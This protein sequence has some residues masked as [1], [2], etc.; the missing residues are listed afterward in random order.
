[1]ALGML[2]RWATELST[3]GSKPARQSGVARRASASSWRRTMTQM[4]NLLVMLNPRAPF[5]RQLGEPKALADWQLLVGRGL[6]AIGPLE[7]FG[8]VA[9]QLGTSLDSRISQWLYVYQ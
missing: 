9:P 5:T 3:L 8:R 2:T 6:E 4:H 1:M 7:S